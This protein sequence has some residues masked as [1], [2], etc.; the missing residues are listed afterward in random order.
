M[1]VSQNALYY[2]KPLYF[3]PGMFFVDI[4]I[5]GY[6][7][8]YTDPKMCIILIMSMGEIVW[9]AKSWENITV[10]LP[11]FFTNMS[12]LELRLERARP[13]LLC[14]GHFHWKI[15]KSMENIANFL[16][17]YVFLKRLIV[18]VGFNFIGAET[19]TICKAR[20]LTRPNFQR[21]AS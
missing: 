5:Q 13:F 4:H 6:Y 7:Q 17:W 2:P 12:G 10:L 14:N 21:A 15:F 3:L 11:Y 1:N 19:R 8:L 9:R 20:D 18:L 16:I